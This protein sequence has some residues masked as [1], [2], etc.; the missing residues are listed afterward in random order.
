MKSRLNGTWLASG[1]RE[2]VCDLT[3]NGQ[4]LAEGVALARAR[5]MI[6][7]NRGNAATEIAFKVTRQHADV[8][9][10]ETFALLH[11]STLPAEGTLTLIP[12]EVD[13]SPAILLVGVV[14]VSAAVTYRG[15][16]TVTTYTLR[17]GLPSD[18]SPGD[19]DPYSDMMRVFR[20]PIPDGVKVVE[21]IFTT[22]LSAPPEIGC[23]VVKP[24]AGSVNLGTLNI[25]EESITVNGFIAHFG[26]NTPNG[27]Y[28][29]SGIAVAN[30]ANLL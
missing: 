12:G 11:F 1:G 28:K 20:I 19:I 24:S 25:P 26:A 13:D 29:L 9:T 27:N 3:I 22:P 30:P 6:V 2:S 21:V 18:G 5:Q 17:G 10:A 4:R 16:S 8:P 23:A 15:V 14:L 7:V